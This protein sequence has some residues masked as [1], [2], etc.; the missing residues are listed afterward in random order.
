MLTFFCVKVKE[1][2]VEEQVVRIPN[3]PL[4][5][6]V[7]AVY[8]RK[9]LTALMEQQAGRCGESS[10]GF[11]SSFF[12]GSFDPFEVGEGREWKDEGKED[13]ELVRLVQ[14]EASGVEVNGCGEQ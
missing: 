5:L 4:F 7:V 1:G 11:L 13:E 8:R 6:D 2:F 14:F 10:D 12:M 3:W 9:S